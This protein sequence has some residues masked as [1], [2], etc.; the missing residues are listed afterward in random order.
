MSNEVLNHSSYFLEKNVTIAG[1]Y[2]ST[3]DIAQ[4]IAH[5]LTCS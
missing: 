1:F 3:L 4:V 5:P 2:M